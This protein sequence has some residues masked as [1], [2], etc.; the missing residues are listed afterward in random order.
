MAKNIQIPGFITKLYSILEDQVNN[1]IIQWSP[2]GDAFILVNQELLES[3]VLSRHF[4]HNHYSSFLRQLNMY[5]FQKIR[6]QNNQQVFWHSNFQK[7]KEYFLNLYFCRN[8]LIMMKRNKAKKFSLARF[9]QY[10]MTEISSLK[11]QQGNNE[12]KFTQIVNQHEILLQQHKM[13]YSDVTCQRSVFDEK[14]DRLSSLVYHICQPKQEYDG[15]I[16]GYLLKQDES[17]YGN[18]QI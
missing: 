5:D 8:E 11:Q 13:L 2:A 16:S 3:K 14:F 18:S 6:N 15:E 17:E 9:Q 4:K 1:H 12:M 7:G 10:L